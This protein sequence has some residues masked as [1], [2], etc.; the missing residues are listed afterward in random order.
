MKYMTNGNWIHIWLDRVG[1]QLLD[2]SQALIRVF[3]TQVLPPRRHDQAVDHLQLPKSGNEAARTGTQCLSHMNGIWR[4][5]LVNKPGEGDGGVEHE[6]GQVRPSSIKLFVVML[7]GFLERFRISSIPAKISFK[8]RSGCGGLMIAV[9]LP[10]RVIPIRSP[11]PARSTSS[12]S[13]CLASNRPTVR[14][15]TPYQSRLLS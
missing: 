1:K 15:R 5:G 9:S 7:L 14:I 10:R 6:P 12:E 13:F 8:L 4:H 2:K 11:L 3:D